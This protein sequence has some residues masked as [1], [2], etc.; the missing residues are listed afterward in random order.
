MCVCVCV[1]ITNTTVSLNSVQLI[2][3]NSDFSENI[4]VRTVT[5][6]CLFLWNFVN[7]I[8]LQSMARWEIA[9]SLCTISSGV[10]CQKDLSIKAALWLSPL[11]LFR[12]NRERNFHRVKLLYES[13][14]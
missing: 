12:C 1:C 9:V 10:S 3:I 11:R 4:L 14:L 6:H 7:L 5:Y 2:E 8:Q 13:Q